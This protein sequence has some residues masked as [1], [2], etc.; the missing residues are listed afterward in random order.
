MT[1][2]TDK[3]IRN[4]FVDI[5]RIQTLGKKLHIAQLFI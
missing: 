4:F 1:P 2:D 3:D 5:S